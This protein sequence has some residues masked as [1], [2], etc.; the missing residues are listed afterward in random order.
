MASLTYQLLSVTVVLGAVQLITGY[1]F[2]NCIEDPYSNGQ[3]FNCIRRKEKKM[4]AFIN[5]LPLSV[6]N[7]TISLNNHLWHI[8]NKSFVHLPNL[9]HLRVDH[10]SLRIIDQF[11]FQNLHQ[12]KSLNVSFNKISELN[13]SLFKDLHNLTFLSLT[14]NTLKQLPKGI[15]S[16]VLNLDTLIMRQNFLAN[17]SGIAE[18]VSHLM[19]LRILDLCFNSL[20]SLSHSNVSL[21]KSLTTLYICRNNL[22]TLGCNHSFLGFI[23]LLDLS[24][25]SRLPTMAFQGVDLR[26]INYLRLRSTSVKVVEFLNIS[27]VNAGHVDFSGTGLKNSTLLMELCRLL[28]RK[29]KGITNLHLGNNG[30][31]NLKNSTLYYCPKI[32]GV[33]DLSHNQLKRISF[34]FLNRQTYIK[35]F[36]A[37]HN[38]LTLLPSSKTRNMVYLRNLE[39]LSYRY[40]RI[41][42]VN[43][44][45]FYH[46]PNIKILKL[47]INTIAFLDR[48]ALKGLKRL[49]TLRLDNNLLT[50][51]FNN[52]F[53]DN[54]NLQVLNLRNNR[55]SVIFNGT[56]LSLRNL[57]TLD[58]GGNKITHFQPSGLDGLK[59]LSKFYLDGNNLKQIDT[60]LYRVFQDTLTVLDLQS[61]QIR[62]LT[63]DISSPFMNLSKLSD[64]KL[65]GQRPY[66]LTVLPR[67]FFRGLH[68]LKSL[69][70]THNNIFHLTPDVF[71]DLT[72]LHFL[73]LDNCCVGV[74]QLQPGIFKNLRNLT[75]LT[76]ENMGIQNFSKEVFGNL[77]QLRTLQ[78]NRNVMQHI[79]VDALESL[80]KLHYLDIRNI[81]L[82]CT[83]KNS[84][85]QN[86]TVHNPNVQ[87]V[88]LYNL[89][90]PHDVKLKF[91]NFDTKVC[92]IDLGVYLFFSTAVVVFLFTVAPLLHVKL[93]WKM[94]YSY[95]V[96]RSWFSEQW[97]R[98]REEE[99]NCKYDAFISYNSSDE[100]WVMDQLLPNLEGNGSSFK[101]C[102]HHRD[103]EL[104]R[105]IVDNIVSAVYSSRKTICVVSRN[106][107]RS[108]WCSLEIQL[109]SYRLFDEHRDVLL[110][111]FLEP[112]SERQVS[113][114]H[115][116]RKVM[117]KKT[118]LQW[119]GSDCTNPTQ[120][121]DL[122]WNQLRRAMR[123]GSR[124]ETE[125]EN[126]KSDSCVT[127][128]KETEHF[129]THTSDENYYLLP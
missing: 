24:Y 70:L 128:S 80:P 17:F 51:L 3:S 127:E 10:N 79:H 4:S 22:F 105:D 13:P 78:L 26:R 110:L 129:E 85:L 6:I 93:Y 27:N 116:M 2:N 117:L 76:V 45:A 32:T 118:Y 71:D 106:F 34:N 83:C 40:N 43:S 33:L 7:L 84:L 52:T 16:T 72:G 87:V 89:P 97:R 109:A 99:E 119:P 31:E 54:F 125:T 29:V 108:E 39:E 94:K 50:D 20:T 69:Y 44:Y 113:S 90:C 100:Q 120:A 61:N 42:S 122:F 60:S 86:W 11:A 63:E 56:F 77:T 88:Y 121:Q 47:N 96:F 74:T 1:S 14:N 37:E 58:L 114:Y 91:Y 68:S 59:S 102:L 30:I 9:Q 92:Y 107:L 75:K 55:I 62:F 95:Y 104:G 8:P 36:N 101:L 115:R 57:T 48:K 73:T 123:T 12:L 38:H 25:N 66:G 53:E 15:F 103:F 19:N 65:D 5:D 126:Y 46:I 28:K 49:E 111:V 98:F 82:S 67:T 21:P 23:Q 124:L 81:P 112:I 41:L 64:L 35:S 18:S